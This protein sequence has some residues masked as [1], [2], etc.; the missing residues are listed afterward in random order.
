MGEKNAGAAYCRLV[1]K[2]VDKVGMEG[3]LAYL[4]DILV[5]TAS[6]EEHINLLDLLFRAHQRLGIVLK[7]K[8]TELFQSEVNYLGFRVSG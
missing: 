7:A 1:Q 6:L 5:H 3:V 4:D 8:K 2:L